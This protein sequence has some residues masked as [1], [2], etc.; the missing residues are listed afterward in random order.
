M[1]Y[2]NDVIDI[3]RITKNEFETESKHSDYVS[4]IELSQFVF[5]SRSVSKQTICEFI[6]K[7]RPSRM[8]WVEG[9]L[10]DYAVITKRS[11]SMTRNP[12]VA[13]CVLKTKTR[14]WTN[15]NLET[16]RVQLL[17]KLKSL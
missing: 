2:R 8:K 17:G 3:R 1:S 5:F 9:Q 7:T 16:F 14:L 10:G 13:E 4:P 11:Q 15:K 12:E 6:E